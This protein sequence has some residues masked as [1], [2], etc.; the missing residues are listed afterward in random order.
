MY[1]A[2]IWLVTLNFYWFQQNKNS[3]NITSKCCLSSPTATYLL[4]FL[5]CM[6]RFL[7]HRNACCYRSWRTHSDEDSNFVFHTTTDCLYTTTL[8]HLIPSLKQIIQ[9]MSNF[10]KQV[11]LWFYDYIVHTNQPQISVVTVM[12]LTWEEKDTSPL[13]LSLGKYQ[14]QRQVLKLGMFI[15]VIWWMCGSSAYYPA[16][17]FVYRAVFVLHVVV[18]DYFVSTGW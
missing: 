12:I 18:V 10:V 17:W 7:S 5:C 4:F 9:F 3:K 15:V 2:T 6:V 8:N 1:G 16:G 13:L 14:V 11:V